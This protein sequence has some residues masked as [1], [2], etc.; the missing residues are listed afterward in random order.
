MTV[1]VEGML[2]SIPIDDR[3][4][5]QSAGECPPSFDAL[6]LDII[7]VFQQKSVGLAVDLGQQALRAHRSRRE[8]AWNQRSL[9]GDVVEKSPVDTII[10]SIEVDAKG[11]LDVCLC[12]CLNDDGRHVSI[13]YR[14]IF[15]D[16]R[17]FCRLCIGGVYDR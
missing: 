1:Q 2:A 7:A 12:L 8:K 10:C 9:V 17:G 5:Q 11:D 15:V 6:Q 4:T 13:R 14:Q 3:S 16:F